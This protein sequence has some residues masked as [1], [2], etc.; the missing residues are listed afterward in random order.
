MKNRE[1]YNKLIRNLLKMDYIRSREIPNIDL[2]MDQVTTF[3]EEHL[4]SGKRY[5]QD[6]IL[7]KTMINNY[8]KNHLLPAPEKKKYSKDH[9]LLLI[10]IY[11]FKSYLSINDIQTILNP[12]TESF[13]ENEEGMGM[14]KI[15]EEV[16]SYEKRSMRAL[17]EDLNDSFHMAMSSFKDAPEEKQE[18]LQ[19]FTFICILSFDVYLKKQM[20]ETIIDEMRAESEREQQEEE[21][22]KKESKKEAKKEAKKENKEAKKET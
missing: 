5:E 9:L 21:A 2:Y 17:I 18:Y 7:T 19:M 12:I 4:K 1:M 6:K 11:Y 10:F 22:I 16:F 15:Y 13:F 3:M 20:I 8:A 14:E